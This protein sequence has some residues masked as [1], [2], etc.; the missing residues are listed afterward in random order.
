MTLPLTGG[1]Q[2][3]GVRYALRAAPEAVY[4]CHCTGCCK[5]PGPAFGI[6]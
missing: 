6:S 5:Q 2:C 3:K 4:V 1:C